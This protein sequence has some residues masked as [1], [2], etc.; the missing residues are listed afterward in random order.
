[1]NEKLLSAE[2]LKEKVVNEVSNLK[3]GIYNYCENIISN[4]EEELILG[5]CCVKIKYNQDKVNFVKL[6]YIIR[7]LREL[8]YTVDYCQ[9]SEITSVDEDTYFYVLTVRV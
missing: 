5:K 8:G 6:T 2:E 9:D 4:L 7:K 1:M 3:N